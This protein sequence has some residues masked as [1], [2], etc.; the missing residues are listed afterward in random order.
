MLFELDIIYMKL[1]Y[2]NR[3]AIFLCKETVP[4]LDPKSILIILD[5]LIHLLGDD[6]DDD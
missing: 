6:D 4:M 5:I 3:E 1:P 2:T